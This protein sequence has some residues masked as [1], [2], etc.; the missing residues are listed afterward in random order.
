[1]DKEE[2]LKQGDDTMICKLNEKQFGDRIVNYLQS[3][4]SNYEP[5]FKVADHFQ[6]NILIENSM[7][8]LSKIS[9]L[10]PSLRENL[11]SVKKFFN[12]ETTERIEDHFKHLSE[13]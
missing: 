10:T 5:K 2:F 8:N 9:L 13:Q 6:E 11:N 3:K 4:T 1:M 7:Q 12:N